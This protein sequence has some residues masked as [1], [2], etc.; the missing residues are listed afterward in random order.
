ME[1]LAPL[2]LWS[3]FIYL[4][5]LPVQYLF[6]ALL[7]GCLFAALP[8]TVVL[9]AV[10]YRYFEEPLIRLGHRLKYRPAEQTALIRPRQ[11]Q[12]ASGPARQMQ[13]P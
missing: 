12:R 4:F 1:A 11:E 7:P 3:Y 5:H 10:S 9:A 2:G 6:D 13:G 8:V